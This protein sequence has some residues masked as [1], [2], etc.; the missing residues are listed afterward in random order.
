MLSKCYIKN[1]LKIYEVHYLEKDLKNEIKKKYDIIK[2]YQY[3]N[4]DKSLSEF[5]TIFINLKL[6]EEEILN[7][8]AKNT[9]YE[10]KRNINK[11]G[12]EYIFNSNVSKD[13]IDLFI[14]YLIKFQAFKH[15]ENTSNNIK[16]FLY[17]F[18]ENIIFSKAVKNGENLV[19]HVYIVD[20]NRA[21]LKCSVSLREN[22]NQEK[23]NL[24]GRSNRGLHFKDIIY[25]KNM[26]I[27]IYDLGGIYIGDK[28]ID[29]KNITTFKRGFGGAEVVEYEGNK[30]ISL[31]GKFVL[32]IYNILRKWR[33]L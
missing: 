1:R 9:K 7:N 13:E 15:V 27:N 21:R 24:I 16:Q 30:G 22:L 6:N 18:K 33:N 3:K 4:F 26:N 2:Y 28:D 19:W 32:F 5:H 12:I 10:I 17:N 11:D 20:D 31:K 14:Q 23:R 8:M 29:K 25:F